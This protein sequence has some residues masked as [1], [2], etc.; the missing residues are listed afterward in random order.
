M[1]KVAIIGRKTSLNNTILDIINDQHGLECRILNFRDFKNEDQ[2][3]LDSAEGV[4]IADLTTIHKN[5]V[6]RI[7]EISEACPK[8]HLVVIHFFTNDEIQ[9]DFLE[10]GADVYLTPNLDE[11][12]LLESIE[13][14]YS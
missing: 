6:I 12:E 5:P 1:K 8:A 4:I 7:Q 13:N 14:F 10:A 9:Q 3:T 2:K 11:E